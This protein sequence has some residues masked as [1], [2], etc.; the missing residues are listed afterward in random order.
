[1]ER[2]GEGGTPVQAPV[3][4]WIS[5]VHTHP[6]LHRQC[7]GQPAR[8]TPQTHPCTQGIV[9]PAPRL[10]TGPGHGIHRGTGGGPAA[11]RG[12][13]DS[14]AVLAARVTHGG[15]TGV[16]RPTSHAGPA[17][18]STDGCCGGTAHCRG[19]TR[20]RLA[21][22]LAFVGLPSLVAAAGASACPTRLSYATTPTPTPKP[23]P[24]SA[25]PLRLGLSSG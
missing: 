10:D 19:P 12:G 15:G 4:I 8:P 22:T 25:C 24:A 3:H 9:Q 5:T 17:C 7:G 1:M 11:A 6:I 13:Q 16:A 18:A 2:D 23:A 14:I 20:T 21:C